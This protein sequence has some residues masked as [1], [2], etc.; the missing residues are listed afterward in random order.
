MRQA[1]TLIELIFVIVIIGL[2]AA[3]AVPKFINLKQHTVANSVVKTTLDA[4]QQAVEAAIN[5]Y[6]L[7]ET[8]NFNLTDLINLTGKGWTNP[9]SNEYDYNDSV[10]N[11]LVASIVLDKTNK[12][13]NYSIDCLKLNDTKAQKYCEGLINGRQTIKESLPY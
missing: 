11:Q 10:N 2:L 6:D 3:I 5:E 7:N 1:F 9:N 12:E 13:I 8:S 4:A